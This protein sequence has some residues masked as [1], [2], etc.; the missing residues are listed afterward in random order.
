[1]PSEKGF[2]WRVVLVR[3]RDPNNIGAVA[4]AMANFGFDDLW[5]VDCHTPVWREATSGIQAESI[6]KTAKAGSLDQA[7]QGCRLVLGTSDHRRKLDQEIV[8]LPHLADYLAEEGL[9]KT[10][11]AILF[12]S[13]KTGLNNDVLARCRARIVIPTAPS[14][15]SMNL[16]HAAAAV[17]YELTRAGPSAK[18]QKSP[19]TP[20]TAEQLEDLVSKALNAFDS[21][22]YMT[23]MAR[24]A[25]AKRL[26][27]MFSGWRLE[28]RDAALLQAVFGRIGRTPSTKTALE[29]K[30]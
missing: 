27:R 29:A 28:R 11:T 8:P 17:F 22:D 24:P 3:P 23:N 10:K 6:L 15:P 26:R 25:K 4:R 18:L 14:A 19:R 12:G 5:V 7:L 2:N 1:M 9:G 30:P 13:E 21:L 16:G 20:P